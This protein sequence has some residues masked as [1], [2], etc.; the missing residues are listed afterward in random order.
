MLER[1]D[2][3]YSVVIPTSNHPG[4]LRRCLAALAQIRHP[5]KEWEVLVMDNSGERFK[6]DNAQVVASFQETRFRYLPMPCLGLM[7]ARHQGVEMARGQVISF[8][9]DDSFVEET[10][11]EGIEQAFRDPNVVLVGG[12]NR[13]KYETNPPAWLDY[14]WT[15]TEQGRHLGYLSLLDFGDRV[16]EIPAVFVFGCNYSIRKN[17]FLRVGGSHPDYMP[18]EWQRYQG[19]GETALSV[20][21]VALGY[22]ARYC[23]QCAIHHLVPTARMTLGY[24]G[25]RAFFV[26][27]HSSFTQI[28]REHGLGQAQGVPPVDIPRQ[29]SPLRLVRAWAG[30]I[31]RRLLPLKPLAQSE[32]EEVLK[33]REHIAKRYAEGWSYHRR[34]VEADPALL[35]YVLRPNYMGENAR[36]PSD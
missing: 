10:W 3:A 32:S 22:K 14:F 16:Q 17:I 9:D 2:V 4:L 11:L 8:I 24:F 19:D 18:P 28:R 6:A 20:K 33:V 31:K 23:P 21:V 34:E 7:A 29:H 1:A 30:R 5:S 13:P 12:P 25:A 35:G 27:L 36:L 26:G 15:Q